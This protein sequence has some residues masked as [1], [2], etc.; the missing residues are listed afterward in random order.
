M[1][2]MRVGVRESGTRGR[3]RMLWEYGGIRT[4]R[5]GDQVGAPYLV[6]FPLPGLKGTA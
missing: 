5:S 2:L 1:L 3:G 4:T 6:P